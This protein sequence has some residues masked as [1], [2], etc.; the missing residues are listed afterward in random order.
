MSLLK[1]PIYKGYYVS[2]KRPSTRGER[3]R[4]TAENWI[5]SNEIIQEFVIIDE[6]IWN[7]AEEIRESRKKDIGKYP[8]STKGPLLLVGLAKCGCCGATMASRYALKKWTRKKDGQE[9]QYL[10][11]KYIC[12]GRSSKTICTGQRTFTQNKVD[13]IVLEEVTTYL[14]SLSRIDLSSKISQ[15][16]GKL[17]YSTKKDLEEIRESILKVEKEIDVLNNEIIKCLTGVSN[18]TSEQLSKIIAKRESEIEALHESENNM[19]RELSSNLR[20]VNSFVE[21][22]NMVPSWKCEFEKV[23]TDVRKMLLSKLID[24]VYITNDTIDVRFKFNLFDL[25]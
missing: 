12:Q 18:F 24:S 15:M 9:L 20:E 22:Q 21:L 8:K 2:G 17:V 6:A 3:K 23:P 25:Q 19:N 13:P 16:Q 10:Q 7:N 14:D 1:N 4:A 11:P 5:Y